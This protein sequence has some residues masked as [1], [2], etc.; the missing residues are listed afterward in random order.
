MNKEAWN[1]INGA[2][3]IIVGAGSGLS[4][5]AGYNHYHNTE[6]FRNYFSDFIDKYGIRSMWDGFYHI[7]SSL[8]EEWAYYARYIQFMYDAPTGEPY[9][10][11]AKLLKRKEYHILTTNIDMQLSRVFP[12]DKVCYFQGDFRYF[13]CYQPCTDE[14]YYNEPMV[15]EMVA[16]TDRNLRI[17]SELVPRCP[18]C[19]WKMVPWVQDDTFLRGKKWQA[20]YKRY[21][22][23]ARKHYHDRIVLLALGVGDMTPSIIQLPFWRMTAEYPDCFLINVTLDETTPPLQLK[24]KMLNYKMDI[25][26]FL[27]IER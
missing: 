1:F 11:L 7:Y 12:E 5:S 14:I 15:R 9:K 24:G 4:S 18:H 13:Q 3:A 27:E 19:G 10:N 20:S 17:P 23:F 25:N 8:E 2:D 21:T 16:H 6:L 22:D 26:D